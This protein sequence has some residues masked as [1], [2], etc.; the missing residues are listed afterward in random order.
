M[1]I[2]ITTIKPTLS[3]DFKNSLVSEDFL[4]QG[5]I[6][7]SK[8]KNKY[9][10][11][12]FGLTYNTKFG[13][14][15]VLPILQFARKKN[16]WETDLLLP[17]HL[18]QFYHFNKSKIG[19]SFEV[20]GN[21]YNYDYP[22]SLGYNLDKLSYTKINIGLKYE[23]RFM[24]NLVVNIAVGYSVLNDLKFINTDGKIELDLSPANDFF[25]N[26]GAKLQK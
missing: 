2:C 19:L 25:I 17:A 11:Y 23:L 13:N 18:N 15:I 4:L 16:N 26:I 5:S 22:S 8:R 9:F 12:G 21:S 24:E 10:K 7:F 6:L 14:K 3:S 20:K 1:I